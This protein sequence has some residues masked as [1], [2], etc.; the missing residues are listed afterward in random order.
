M[1]GAGGWGEGAVGGEGKE[2]SRCGGKA[3]SLPYLPLTTHFHLSVFQLLLINIAKNKQLVLA[4]QLFLLQV[5]TS[6]QEMFK[7][8]K[9]SNR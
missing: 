5:F 9:Q 4:S 7:R 1:G 3:P 2:G 6:I 8:E